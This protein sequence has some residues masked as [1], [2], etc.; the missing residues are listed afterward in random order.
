MNSEVSTFRK[1]RNQTPQEENK[2]AELQQ[3]LLVY[4]EN[5]T[6]LFSRKTNSM[7]IEHSTLPINEKSLIQL[8]TNF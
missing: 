1:V 2:N 8:I 5:S 7:L 4:I 6:Q 3:L